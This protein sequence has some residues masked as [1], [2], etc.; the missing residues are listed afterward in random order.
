M[1][2]DRMGCKQAAK[3]PLM[4]MSGPLIWTSMGGWS[5]YTYAPTDVAAIQYCL[6]S[7]HYL[8]KVETYED[9]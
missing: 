1:G 2:D 4:Y 8:K 3:L 7:E 5:R 9:R 6:P